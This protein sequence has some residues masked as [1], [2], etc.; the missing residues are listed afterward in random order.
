MAV[1]QFT[2][3]LNG[4]KGKIGGGIFQINKG[5]QILRNRTQFNKR[6]HPSFNNTKK[7]L[8][9]VAQHWRGV[10]AV[11]KAGWLAQTV[12]YPTVDKFGNPRTPSAFE[13]FCRLNFV[14]VGLGILKIDVAP[15][16]IALTNVGPVTFTFGPGAQ[17]QVNITNNITV[18]ER[19]LL[20]LSPPY[21]RGRLN[22]S[23]RYRAIALMVN[24]DGGVKDITG[25]YESAFGTA[26]GNTNVFLK[27]TVASS[28]TGQ[29][30]VP[31]FVTEPF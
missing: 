19:V 25:Q 10:S 16:P 4:I 2:G 21:S 12:N 30:G 23:V 29:Q 22:N 14:L 11:D 18:N 1:V 9:E 7:L 8:A 15:A 3:L 5:V 27:A 6:Y 13:L 31:T 26:I 20:Q 24:A 28:V 17:F